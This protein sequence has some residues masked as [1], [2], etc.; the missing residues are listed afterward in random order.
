MAQAKFGDTVRVHYT[1]KLADGT[2]FDSSVDRVPL[3]FTIGQGYIIPGFEQAV[4]GMSPGESKVTTIPVEL[5]Y[6]DHRQ[7]LVTEIDRNQLPPH[8]EPEVGQQLQIIGMDG[9]ITRVTVTHVSES[10][11]VL[12]ANHPLAGKELTFEIQLLEIL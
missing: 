12:D 8:I 1:G 2:I 3:Q 9:Q 10:T 5:A 11:I 7:E 6:G 4:I